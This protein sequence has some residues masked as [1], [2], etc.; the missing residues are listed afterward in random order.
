MAAGR[1]DRNHRPHA[2]R[3]TRFCRDSLNSEFVTVAISVAAVLVWIGITVGL[4]YAHVAE[5]NRFRV[6]IIARLVRIEANQEK[7]VEL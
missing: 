7:R 1:A 2:W 4:F 3:E 6:E 5:C